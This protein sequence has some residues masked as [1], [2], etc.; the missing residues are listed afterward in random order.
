MSGV[1]LGAAK[2]TVSS[3]PPP[4]S[5]Q[6]AEEGHGRDADDDEQVVADETRSDPEVVKNWFPLPDKYADP[7]KSGLTADVKSGQP[8]DIDLK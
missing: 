1:K 8:V 2:V 7:A 5:R 4:G 6:A 3:P